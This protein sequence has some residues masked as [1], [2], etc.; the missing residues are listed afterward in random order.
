MHIVDNLLEQ[1]KSPHLHWHMLV[2]ALTQIPTPLLF[3]CMV[4]EI[5]KVGDLLK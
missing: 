1:H 4:T 5:K 3:L 2:A